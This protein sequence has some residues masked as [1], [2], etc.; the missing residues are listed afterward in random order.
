[1]QKMFPKILAYWPFDIIFNQKTYLNDPFNE[2][3]LR[4]ALLILTI[5]VCSFIFYQKYS[6]SY[7]LLSIIRNLIGVL[8]L[9]LFVRAFSEIL[10]KLISIRKIQLFNPLL[11]A[12]YNTK[13]FSA[14]NNLEYYSV[15]KQDGILIVSG[16]KITEEG[17]I[18]L[19][20][21]QKN[22]F[23]TPV[24]YFFS[25]LLFFYFIKIQAQ[26]NAHKP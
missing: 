6:F 12:I 14:R 26:R 24:V 5:I 9:C 25:L 1:M 13:I 20:Q 22:A 19:L 21:H 10:T 18:F 17:S 15:L 8:I 7:I 11:I 23:A 2:K 16:R 3:I 4:A